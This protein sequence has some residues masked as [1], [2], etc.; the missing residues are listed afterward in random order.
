ML[1]LLLFPPFLVGCNLKNA[2][3]E[4]F[5]YG[6]CH[7]PKRFRSSVCAPGQPE[8]KRGRAK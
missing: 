1:E 7:A 2:E 5:E 4:S 3:I 8:K 6:A